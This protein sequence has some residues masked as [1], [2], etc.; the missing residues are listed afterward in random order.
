MGF[1]WRIWPEENDLPHGF[2]GTDP[3]PTDAVYLADD[4]PM[5]YFVITPDEAEPQ[6]EDG[7]VADAVSLDD[8]WA[9]DDGAWRVVRVCSISTAGNHEQAAFAGYVR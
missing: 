1:V 4:G 6:L 3:S 9:Y 8:D 5:G 7:W 2:H